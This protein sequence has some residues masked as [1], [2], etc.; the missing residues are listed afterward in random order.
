[1]GLLS[2]AV[3]GIVDKL[4]NAAIGAACKVARDSMSSVITSYNSATYMLRGATN[5][6]SYLLDSTIGQV[7]SKAMNDASQAWSTSGVTSGVTSVL[8]SVTANGASLSSLSNYSSSTSSYLSQIQNSAAGFSTAASNL[9]SAK[10]NL[11]QAN[12]VVASYGNS[13][14]GVPTWATDQQKTAAAALS[15]AQA[16]YNAT[17][18]QVTAPVASASSSSSTLSTGSSL[19]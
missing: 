13:T 2:S 19:F 11:E 18:S 15:Q 9:E 17:K 1:M 12:S 6:P 7:S 14:T 8:G 10:M 5:A 3:S 16:T 4:K